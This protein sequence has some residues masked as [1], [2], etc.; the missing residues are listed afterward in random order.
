MEESNRGQQFILTRECLL[1]LGFRSGEQY[2]LRNS[3]EH[4]DLETMCSADILGKRQYRCTWGKKESINK[5]IL[6]SGRGPSRN[7]PNMIPAYPANEAQDED[8]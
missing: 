5:P 8:C 6:K 1:Q 2:A 7:N 4:Q 3:Q